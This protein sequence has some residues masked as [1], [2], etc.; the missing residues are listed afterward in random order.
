MAQGPFSSTGSFFVRDKSTNKLYP[1]T[2][3]TY[4]DGTPVTQP[5]PG[6]LFPPLIGGVPMPAWPSSDQDSGD[7][8]EE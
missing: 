6:S 5:P 7:D 3:L 2:F 4:A 8:D 1:A